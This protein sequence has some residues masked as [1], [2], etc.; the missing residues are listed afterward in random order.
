VPSYQA[1]ALIPPKRRSHAVKK[2]FDVPYNIYIIQ[3][4]V[5]EAVKTSGT[6]IK[7]KSADAAE[8]IKKK[9]RRNRR[10][11]QIMKKMNDLRQAAPDITDINIVETGRKAGGTISEGIMDSVYA[12][13]DNVESR[14][15]RPLTAKSGKKRK[16][17]P[18]S[19]SSRCAAAVAA[20][21][22]IGAAA[23]VSAVFIKRH[24][25]LTKGPRALWDGTANMYSLRYAANHKTF[26]TLTNMIRDELDPSMR[27]LNIACGT[28]DIAR[29]TA[30]VCG[31][32]VACDFSEN[33]IAKAQKKGTPDNL[34]WDIQ[35]PECLTYPDNSFDAVIIANA[36]NIFDEPEDVLDQAARVLKPNGVL[37][38]PNY[39]RN[40]GAFEDTVHLVKVFMGHPDS[41]EWTFDEYKN[42]ITLNGWTILR[43]D[44]IP[45]SSA[46]AFLVA[47]KN[48]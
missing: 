48:A 20:G 9:R 33:I 22:T 21:V 26:L 44:L 34:M 46:E 37:I 42:F 13:K 24:V 5:P 36:L 23:A 17:A 19:R 39:V 12:V 47:S 11:K 16:S 14:I 35:E 32:V 31:P 10:K 2:R 8:T 25:N 18:A 28:G 45:G 40:G 27:V 30:D 41:R 3:E 29:S 38:A 4:K 15:N 6:Y 1:Y 43:E 7:E